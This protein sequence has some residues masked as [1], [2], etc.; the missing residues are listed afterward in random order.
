MYESLL[1]L[2]ATAG[3]WHSS[4]CR[5]A[6]PF[7]GECRI[8]AVDSIDTIAMSRLFS[9][10]DSA[11][12]DGGNHPNLML[13]QLSRPVCANGLWEYVVSCTDLPDFEARSSK[14]RLLGVF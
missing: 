5:H 11:T 6:P 10:F 2:L 3:M 4:P 13:I 7:A 14:N 1:G 9:S 12:V 8:K